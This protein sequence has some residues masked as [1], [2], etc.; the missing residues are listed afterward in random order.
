MFG[1]VNDQALAKKAL[2]GSGDA[3]ERLVKKHEK[4]IY[5]YGLRML[6]SP[7]QA[8]DL[9]QET[10]FA[11]FRNLHQYDGVGSFSGWILKIASN[12]CIDLLRK[13]NPAAPKDDPDPAFEGLTETRLNPEETLH[14]SA[15]KNRLVQA[16]QKLPPE[17]AVILE[18]K[19]FHGLT[20]DE[21][22]DHCGTSTNTVKSRFY[23]ALKK[24][25]IHLEAQ[26]VA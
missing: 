17:Q 9:L 5:N 26:N 3:W 10:F 18:L 14:L 19:F 1:L 4:N 6:G 11:V 13:R 12:R 22:A 15:E 20:L 8:L 16:M 23:S 24:M 21:V 25:K 2:E 7:D